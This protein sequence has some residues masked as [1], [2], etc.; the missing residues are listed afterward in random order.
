MQIVLPEEIKNGFELD[1]ICDDCGGH[2]Q[3]S[4]YWL[5]FP[6]IDK[7]PD[8]PKIMCQLCKAHVIIN[9]VNISRPFKTSAFTIVLEI[10]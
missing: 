6:L 9:L 4:F 7:Y 8:T 3:Q 2:V 1:Y 5:A 10:Y